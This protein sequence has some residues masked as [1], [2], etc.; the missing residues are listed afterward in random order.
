MS[1]MIGLMG[2]SKLRGQWT[3]KAL[4]GSVAKGGTHKLQDQEARDR[5]DVPCPAVPPEA[6]LASTLSMPH[7]TWLRCMH[8]ETEARAHCF[9]PFPSGFCRNNFLQTGLAR[10]RGVFCVETMVAF[11]PGNNIGLPGSFTW[12]GLPCPADR[13]PVPGL[14]SGTASPAPGQAGREQS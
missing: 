14:H 1:V 6:P 4:D 12:Q 13:P 10:D 7:G 11:S 9:Q 2:K 8:G 5:L 3:A